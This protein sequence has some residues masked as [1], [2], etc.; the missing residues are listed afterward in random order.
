MEVEV[1]GRG[2][3]RESV[4]CDVKTSDIKCARTDLASGVLRVFSSVFDQGG[5]QIWVGDPAG[6]DQRLLLLHEQ[7]VCAQAFLLHKRLLAV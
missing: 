2:G 3:F 5:G 1:V 6:E 4:W 7:H